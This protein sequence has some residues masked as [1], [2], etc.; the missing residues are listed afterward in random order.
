M[1]FSDFKAI[2]D[3]QK[4]FG[5]RHIEND[6]LKIEE[7]VSSATGRFGRLGILSTQPSPKTGQVLA[8]IIC[9]SYL[10]LLILFSKQRASFLSRHRPNKI[11]NVICLLLTDLLKNDHMLPR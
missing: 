2:P 6:F 7:T 11:P 8:W 4:K 5:I 1:A 3:V 10:V 9:L